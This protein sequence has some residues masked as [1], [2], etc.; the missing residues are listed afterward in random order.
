MQSENEGQDRCPHVGRRGWLGFC[1]AGVP[2]PQPPCPIWLSW[3]LGPGSLPVK[4]VAGHCVQEEGHHSV[5]ISGT[6][7]HP[8]GENVSSAAGCPSPTPCCGKPVR[9][10]KAALR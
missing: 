9:G 1:W 8:L 2:A 4:E 6:R 3:A 5:R 7:A 10:V